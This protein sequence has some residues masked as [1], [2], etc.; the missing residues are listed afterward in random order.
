MLFRSPA[1][2]FSDLVDKKNNMKRSKY[3]VLWL[4]IV[5]AAAIMITLLTYLVK[6]SDFGNFGIVVGISIFIC[7]F[8]GAYA[9][10]ISLEGAEI[11]GKILGFKEYLRVAEVDKLKKLVDENPNYFYDII[12]YAYVLNLSDAFIE[13]FKVI[14]ADTNYNYGMNGLEPIFVYGIMNSATREIHTGIHNYH[15]AFGGKGGSGFS[16]SGF[17]S[18]GFSGGGFGGGGGG[19]W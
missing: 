16:S 7:S 1:L 6:S 17:S 12:P 15:Q 4:L 2:F 11:L 18:G 14:Q 9:D 3:I 13:K 8:F 10:A 19:S 5:I